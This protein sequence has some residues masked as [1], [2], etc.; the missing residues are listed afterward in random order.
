MRVN[1]NTCTLD[2]LHEQAAEVYGTNFGHN[3]I[4][5]ICQVAKNRFGEEAANEI[6]ETYQVG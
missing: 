5:L 6:F 4:A 3:I 2:E 1:I